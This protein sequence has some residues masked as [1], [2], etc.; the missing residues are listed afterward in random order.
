MSNQYL[1]QLTTK[2]TIAATDL[3]F[4]TD[5]GV[6]QGQ[7]VGYEY[8]LGRGTTYD[9]SPVATAWYTGIFDGAGT[10]KHT[11]LDKIAAAGALL[12]DASVAGTGDQ[13]LLALNLTDAV[14]LTISS[15]AV[16]RTQGLHTIDT[17]SD[18]ATDDLDT[19]NG[20][21]SGDVL[22]I[23]PANDARTVV[24]K[25]G[26]GNI[27]CI[28]NA[29]ITLDD[30]HDLCLL[31]SDGTNWNAASFGAA[32]A[33]RADASV[34]GTG[35]QEFLGINFTDATEL[36]ISSGAITKTQGYHTVD[37]ESD[38]A[39]DDLDTISGG[40]EGDM[41][42]IRAVNSARTVTVKHATGNINCVGDADVVLDDAHDMAFLL[43]D[44]SNWMAGAFTSVSGGGDTLPVADT[45]TLVKGSA[46]ATKLVRIEADTN[47][48]TGNARVLVMA[49]RDVDL[50][51]P[52]FDG[53]NFATAT[54]LTIAVGSV[55][56][57]QSYHTIDTEADAATDDL[58]TIG[59]G[60]E[61]DILYIRPANSARTIVVKHG[62]GNI[63]IHGDQDITLDD[64]HDTCMLIYDGSNWL[65]SVLNGGGD[66]LPV[67]DTQTIVKGSA[68]ATKLMRIE[69]DTNVTTGTTRVL[70]MADRDLDL[71]DPIFDT[72]RYKN[73]TELTIAT[74]VV[75][76]TQSY[77]TIDTEA[78]AASDDLDT[79]NGTNLQGKWLIVF[80]DNDARTVVLKH[81]TGNITTTTGSDIT[82][83]SKNKFALLFY[84]VTTWRAAEFSGGGGGDTLPVTDST[85]IAKGSVDDTKKVRWE[86]DTHV[87]SGQTRVITAPEADL[88][89]KD[90]IFDTV[91]VRKGSD[92][93]ISAGA[94]TITD[95]WH[96]VDTELSAST[97]DLDTINGGTTGYQFLILSAN[98][99]ANTVVI[100][101]GTGNIKTMDGRDIALDNDT[102]C[103]LLF[104]NVA[105]SEWIAINK[106]F[107]VDGDLGTSGTLTK[108]D[109][110]GTLTDSLIRDDGSTVAVGVAPG[111]RYFT[112][113]KSHD[114]EFLARLYNSSTTNAKGL[115][116][117][118]GDGDGNQILKLD[119]RTG[120]VKFEVL[121]TSIVRLHDA[122][123]FV[124][125]KKTAVSYT[126]SG[127]HTIGVTDTSS[128]RT[129]TLA[130]A[131]C[132][133]GRRVLVKDESGGAMT[134]NITVDT[135]GSQNI[136]GSA[137]QLITADYGAM[138]LYSDGSNWFI[139]SLKNI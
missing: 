101:H 8:L 89:L 44:G 87:P 138:A 93:T 10:V 135:Q 77:H 88:D 108:V 38:A 5:N 55:T 51:F 7:G 13:E 40:S 133:N 57:T 81:G 46:D 16:T 104:Y 33:I 6:G 119:D 69:V 110:N 41:L 54:E 90:P 45:Q 139:D 56:R 82:L 14:E 132:K 100:K 102:K 34:A 24:V 43:Y 28:D 92:L 103:V 68:D 25:H 4:S 121:D 23:R 20:D 136:D 84:D 52:T 49:D 113:E 116:V 118:A 42:L 125:I 11:R 130:T 48:T 74:G 106:P 96:Q 61:G 75:T 99:P 134:N 78:D 98:L 60:T 47:I 18:A 50:Q 115:N 95:G 114:S 128:P 97:D 67:A 31:V 70:T 137:S 58:D 131:D 17:E 86:V 59:N 37:T 30:A 63:L 29:D 62:T 120:D 124:G 83:D 79:I 112:I 91:S 9:G 3:F 72:V 107:S 73:A 122:V 111:S 32:G 12:A 53:V 36:T 65:A 94:I 39:T 35:M 129:I 66:T 15:G 64:A 21:A 123:E 2:T 22:I 76:I 126:T 85:A 105:G 27:K 1:Q 26:T 117:I 71:Q 109:G 19:I 127:E 80:P